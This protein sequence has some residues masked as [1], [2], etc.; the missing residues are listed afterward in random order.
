MRRGL[1]YGVWLGG[2]FGLFRNHVAS[3]REQARLSAEDERLAQASVVGGRGAG[4]GRTRHSCSRFGLFSHPVA[5]LVA[6]L[7]ACALSRRTQSVVF[8]GHPNRPIAL[9][10]CCTG[11]LYRVAALCFHAVLLYRV[12]IPGWHNV[13]DS[14]DG[15]R[16]SK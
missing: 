13:L 2:V 8:R 15:Y 14:S 3:L 1:F 11:L 9:E 6:R 12:I 16:A 10:G 7:R 4:G 5:Y